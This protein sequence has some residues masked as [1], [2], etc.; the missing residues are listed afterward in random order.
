ML[1]GGASIIAMA[2]HAH[3]IDPRQ[4]ADDKP[5]PGAAILA[6]HSM[7]GDGQGS[8]TTCGGHAAGRSGLA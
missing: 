4:Q 7:V 1:F 2:V 6:L 8:I 5:S 3:S